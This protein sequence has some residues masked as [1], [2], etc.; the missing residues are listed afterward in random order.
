MRGSFGTFGKSTA[1]ALALAA[2]LVAG[3]AVLGAGA[4]VAKE[5]KATN[6]PEF[7][8]AAQVLQKAVGEVAASK[9]KAAAQAVAAQLAAAEGSVKTPADR[10]IYGQWQQQIGGIA[11]DGA[12]SQKGLQNMADSGQLAPDKVTL[13]NY[14][15]GVTAYQNKDYA[16]AVKVLSPVVAANYSDDSAA[17]VLASS[18]S[19]Q[20]QN[21]QAIEALKGAIAAR[22][23][24]GG[25]VP[26]SW[27]K[28]GNLI[29]YNAKLGPQAIEIS[30]MQVAANPTALNWLGAGQLVRE[31]GSFTK[32]E[33]LDLGRLFLRTGALDND[34]KYVEREYIEYIQSADPRRLPG[35]VQAVTEQGIA[36]GVIK[37]SDPFIADALS[38]SKSRVAADRASLPGLDKGARAG[39]NGKAAL[40]SGDAYLSY[41]EAAKA[42]EMYQ[43]A[44]IKGG[45][46]TDRAL[47]RLGIAQV[48]EGKAA[49]A[50]A[51]FAKVGGTR[52]PLAKL[53]SIYAGTKAAK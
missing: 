6:S 44:L 35:E 47:T 46:D 14:F 53:W 49:D 34:P 30:T 22:K 43:L 41:G 39:V 7:V 26:D 17:E 38:Q 42:E 28:R 45:I 4:A 25:V 9:D 10:I 13:V 23:A 1:A 5:A 52:A 11:G 27:F 48:D 31:F 21:A 40:A 33:S 20:G 50:Q 24:A 29:A 32:E 18:L 15:L 3:G 8:K 36:K 16:T 19:E 2:G 51:T 12:L 37:T